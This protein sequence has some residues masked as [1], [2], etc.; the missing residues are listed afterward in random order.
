M[1]QQEFEV[2]V[3]GGSYSGL[4]AAMS[5]GRGIRKT[6]VIDSGLPCNRQTPHS[7]NFITQDGFSPSQ[8]VKTAR[9]QV[10][11]Y[12]TVNFMEDI[13]LQVTGENNN[14]TVLTATGLRLNAKKVLFTTGVK[15]LLPDLQGLSSCWGISVIHCPYC[16]G[17]EYKGR[18]TGILSNDNTT[19]HL[20]KLILNW[21]TDLTVFTNGKVLFNAEEEQQIK[22]Q[23][24]AI[25]EKKIASLT[26]KE[27]HLQEILFADGTLQKVEAIYTRPPFIQH[28]PIPETMGC[29]I[30]DKGLIV[31]DYFRKTNVSGIFAAGDC[32]EIMRSVSSAVAAGS[33]AGASI[34]NELI[35][36]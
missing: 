20:S 12:P 6:L 13:V 29:Q 10:S 22:A 16:H 28:C 1:E 14:F 7:H 18:P 19:L 3:I 17:Y 32:T 21:T 26:H 31:V 30:D 4:S 27:G 35:F 9:D 25:V 23:N 8:I 36:S 2:I 11:E 34:N 5:L 15:D 24:V 33:F